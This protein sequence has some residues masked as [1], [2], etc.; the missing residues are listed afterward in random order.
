[1]R[2]LKLTIQYDG[3]DYHGFQIQPEAVT[4]QGV[5]EHVLSAVTGE[6]IHVN[7][8]SRTDAGVHAV[9]Y[10]C[11]FNTDFPIPPGRL[12]I[13]LN[14]K[15]PKSIKALEC[16][17]VPDN[18]HARYDTVS[19][20]YRYII[21][22]E[23]SPGVFTR[24]F[25]W[26]LKKRLDVDKMK[27]AARYITGTHDFRCFMTSG[28]DVSSTVRTV[29]DLKITYN[30]PR[31]LIF[32]RADGYLYNMVRIITGTLA[33]V[34]LGKTEPKELESIIRSTSRDCAGPTAPAQ[35]LSLFEIEY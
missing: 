3:T 20:T 21:N 25:E 18:F 11:S 24:N 15:L 31:V 6:S 35:G 7:G 17:Q 34:G 28:T 33:D 26:Q 9:K 19:K 27:E 12:P 22:T 10:V 4:V 2:N 32:I 16:E 29:F 5:L 8:C 13:V 1:M 23:P 30:E 14:N